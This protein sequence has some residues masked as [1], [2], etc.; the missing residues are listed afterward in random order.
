MQAVGE[1]AADAVEPFLL[2]LT[3]DIKVL[4]QLA[5]AVGKDLGQAR[6]RG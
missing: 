4:A 3:D 5:F 1:R 6:E 2:R